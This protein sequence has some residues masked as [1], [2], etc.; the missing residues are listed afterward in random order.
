MS[1]TLYIEDG[2][3]A[4]KKIEAIPG[5][6]PEVKVLYRPALQ[7]EVKKWQ[8]IVGNPEQ[9]TKADFDL[10]Q[11]HVVSLNGNPIPKE[12]V[13]KLNPSIIRQLIDL[14]CSYSPA[15]EE[16]DAKNSSSG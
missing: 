9:Q 1:E 8:T 5:L 2:Y 16:Q 6:H 12:K 15:D 13:H 7:A 3:S 4:S 14:I 11:K 10:I